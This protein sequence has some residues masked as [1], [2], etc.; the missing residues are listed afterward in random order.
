MIAGRKS[1]SQRK[2]EQYIK[3]AQKKELDQL[4][5]EAKKILAPDVDKALINVRNAAYLSA[6]FAARDLW[7]F[8]KKR[9]VQ[10][11]KKMDSHMQAMGDG[12][13][14]WYEYY[15]VLLDETGIEGAEI[16]TEAEVK[17]E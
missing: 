2:T 7:G 12:G 11:L 15:Q 5:S 10:L 14:D 8:G 13:A 6:M 9:L 17:Y 3:A 16:T 1:V 4:V